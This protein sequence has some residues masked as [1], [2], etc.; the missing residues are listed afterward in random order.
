MYLSHLS[1]TYSFNS[2]YIVLAF[3]YLKV[4]FSFSLYILLVNLHIRQSFVRSKG[5][6][7]SFARTIPAYA[8]CILL[9]NLKI[10][11]SILKKAYRPTT[12]FILQKAYLLEKGVKMKEQK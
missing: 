3:Y 6:A 5:N 8:F 2:G 7:K 10:A 9:S 4:Y 12:I 1:F 11:L